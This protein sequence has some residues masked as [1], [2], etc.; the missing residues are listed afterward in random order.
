MT[1]SEGRYRALDGS[2]LVLMGSSDTEDGQPGFTS[3]GTATFTEP[4]I[5]RYDLTSGPRT[6][7]L[8][9][10]FD[11][12]L[13]VGM[14]VVEQYSTTDGQISLVAGHTPPGPDGAVWEIGPDGTPVR[15]GV[16]FAVWEGL[17]F[18]LHAPIYGSPS[19]AVGRA[20]RLFEHLRISEDQA[21]IALRPAQRVVFYLDEGPSVLHDVADVALLEVMQLTRR[22]AAV[23]PRQP[24]TVVPGGELFAYVPDHGSGDHVEPA[25]GYLHHDA[26]LRKVTSSAIV[27][28][29]PHERA[30]EDDVMALAVDLRADWVGADS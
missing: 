29:L 20:R 25:D 10:A 13:G 7:G 6:L 17:R 9:V 21:G 4:A 30:T 3:V 14:E 12:V 24:G 18:S 11:P 22:T 8:T 15:E 26:F 27:T 5:G 2:T 23:V 16:T 28:I 1:A 19:V